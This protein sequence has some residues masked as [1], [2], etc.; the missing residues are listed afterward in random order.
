MTRNSF[1]SGECGASGVRKPAA[2]RCARSMV[3]ARETACSGGVGAVWRVR[4]TAARQRGFASGSSSAARSCRAE[5]GSISASGT[6][7]PAFFSSSSR[8]A[9]CSMRLTMFFR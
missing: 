8:L 9:A 1:A 4:S 3:T 2:A 5:S 7:M 6:S